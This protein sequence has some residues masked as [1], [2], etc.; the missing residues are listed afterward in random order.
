M[1]LEARNSK[2]VVLASSEDLLP[3]LSYGREYHMV[4][5]SKHA[6]LV[7]LPFLIM[8]LMPSWWCHP[9]DLR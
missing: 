6:R 5:Q 9:H 4:I 3:A 7:C 8:P 1:V 2:S